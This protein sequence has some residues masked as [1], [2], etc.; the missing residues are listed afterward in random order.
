MSDLVLT[1]RVIALLLLLLSNSLQA[2]EVSHECETPLVLSSTLDW[3]PYLYRNENSEST[4]AD[5]ELLRKVLSSLGCQLIVMQFPERRSLFELEQ[6]RFDIG[7]GASMNEQRLRKFWYSQSYRME[8]N[9]FI[10]R[11]T[12]SDVGVSSTLK[13]IIRLNKII[14][15]N[16]A[17]WYGDEIEQAKADYNN[18]VYSDTVKKRMKMLAS[19][20]VDIVIDDAVVLCSELLRQRHIDLTLHPLVLYETPVHFIFNKKSISED[21]V[22]QVNAV[23]AEMKENGELQRHFTHYLPS[24]CALNDR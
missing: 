15:V 11:T 17:G 20:R 23:I 16:L 13:Q 19:H 12:D 6:G 22:Q 9:K 8:V 1:S 2:R 5:L 4:G 7:I 10:Y 18:F 14:A 24:S 21:F 3:Y